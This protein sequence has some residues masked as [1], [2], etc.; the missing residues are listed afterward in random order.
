MLRCWWRETFL[1]LILHKNHSHRLWRQSGGSRG[2]SL[3]GGGGLSG[4]GS[5]AGGTVVPRGCNSGDQKRAC[6]SSQQI[7]A[8]RLH[9]ML[10]AWK[11]FN[12]SLDLRLWFSVL[13]ISQIQACWFFLIL[14]P[15]P[16]YLL[17]GPLVP[18][19][20]PSSPFLTAPC[21]SGFTCYSVLPFCLY[22]LYDLP[23]TL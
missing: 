12:P 8:I 11:V 15:A 19:S 14:I 1:G 2:R 22:T 7:P 18:D 10:T 16:H 6:T 23:V 17:Y 20:S 9:L 5:P 21:A 3:R 13:P 4:L